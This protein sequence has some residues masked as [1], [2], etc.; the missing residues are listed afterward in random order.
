[1]ETIVAVLQAGSRVRISVSSARALHTVGVAVINVYHP[2]LEK[3]LVQLVAQA[4]RG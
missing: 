3:A 4:T 1:M 2:D